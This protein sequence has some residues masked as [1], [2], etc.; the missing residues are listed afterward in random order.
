MTTTTI[1]TI[2]SGATRYAILS[3]E[4]MEVQFLMCDG[5][6]AVDAIEREIKEMEKRATALSMRA[7][8]IRSALRCAE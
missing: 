1:R 3:R 5:E 2:Q 4:S 6:T 8:R 7:D